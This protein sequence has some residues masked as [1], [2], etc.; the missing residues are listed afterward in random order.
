MR[1]EE[2]QQHLRNDP[3]LPLRV[4]V[5]D[6]S[7]YDVERR[8]HAFLWRRR[9]IIGLNPAPTGV[10]SRSV[11][12]NPVHVTRIEPIVNGDSSHRNGAR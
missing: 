9:L 3:F 10:P 7:A 8:E 11:Y 4:F 1:A 6:G 5:S 12:I 2:I